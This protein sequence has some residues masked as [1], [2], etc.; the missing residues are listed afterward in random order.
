MR[1]LRLEFQAFG[2]FPG[3]QV[4]DF[5]AL[6]KRGLFVVTGPTGTGKTT[7]FD[8]MVYA[9]YGVLPG[10]RSSDG[11]PRSHHAAAEVETYVTLDFEVDGLCYRVHRTPKWD[12]PK[13]TGTGTTLQ[14]PTALVITLTGDA[15]GSSTEALATQANNTT[16]KCEQLVGLD[17]KQFQRVVLLPQGKFTDFL[18]ATDENREQLLRQL[19]GGE[20]FERATALLKKQ[21]LELD[22]QVKGVDTVMQHHRT[23]AVDALITARAAWLTDIDDPSVDPDGVPIA[24][25]TDEDVRQLIHQL[26][27][28]RDEH[29]QRLGSLQRLATEATALVT[30]A[31][32]DAKRFDD[33]VTTT[34]RLNELEAA[35]ESILADESSSEASRRARPVVVASEKVH[36]AREVALAA[37]DALDVVRASVSAGFAVLQRPQPA[38]DAASV[39][40]AVQVASKQ[41]EDERQL[42][43]AARKAAA[44]ATETEG[45]AVAARVEHDTLIA[46]EANMRSAIASL[47]VLSAD[48][49]PV[50]VSVDKFTAGV[51]AERRA[52]DARTRLDE[53]HAQL[54]KS[55]AEE[56]QVKEAYEVVME[57]FVA[58][59]AP[60]LAE[61]LR[62]GQ[63]CP[64]CGSRDHPDPARDDGR[65]VVDHQAVDMARG[66]WSEESNKV[67][68]Y[69]TTIE[70]LR[71]ELG[72]RAHEPIDAFETALAKAEASLAGAIAAAHELTGVRVEL[73][74][75]NVELAGASQ[76]AQTRGT[77][78]TAF[79]A[80]GA[81]EREEA[82]RLAR[83]VGTIDAE[84]LELNL[85][86]AAALQTG[87]VGIAVLFD[88]VA[89]STAKLA[90]HEARLAEEFGA[91]GY[92]DAHTAAAS[93]LAL[94]VETDLAARA[95]TWHTDLTESTTRMKQLTEQGIPDIRPPLDALR[96]ASEEAYEHAIVAAR[97]FTTAANAHGAAAAEL[98]EAAQVATGSADLRRRR[99]TARTVFKTCNGEAGIR[100]KLERWVLAG[101]LDRVTNAANAHLARMSN[102]RYTLSR[103]T[104]GPSGAGGPSSGSGSTASKGGLT[105]E[106]F[107]AH[108]GRAR[109]TAS[110][111]GGEQFQASLSLALGLADVVSHGGTASGKQ[112][113]ALFVDE[114]F[115]SLDPNALDDAIVALSMLQ[116][117]GRMVGA[118]T[119]VEAMK[120]RLHVGIEV[121]ALEDGRGSTLTVNP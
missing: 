1:P 77:E 42:L 8:A 66:K 44:T 34:L 67:I 3:K 69:Q 30:A 120:E 72:E 68:G 49:E 93:V 19:F 112:F 100:V 24:T 22:D 106:V 105:L 92:A 98:D 70:T 35:R 52:L 57:R 2:S 84:A 115:G 83:V 41:L 45:L 103:S 54:N 118:I 23:N 27:P 10:G 86:T 56:A 28:K 47:L 16:K 4:V 50:A 95:L 36:K 76:A 116:S 117:A 55:T 71:S 40:A 15:S 63:R 113:E 13:K 108:T 94:G 46:A 43:A 29:E 33:A 114:G 85:Q 5:E 74:E 121:T 90:G 18:I 11:D 102:H 48:F 81:A 14:Q 17:A 12:R 39:A 62:D 82:D 96:S 31:E 110:L 109:P 53:T 91:S 21:M 58:T 59:Q 7:V 65:D 88:A 79:A 107:D 6:A 80:R 25:L 89:T 38:F 51:S 87:T 32:S 75:R 20:L 111:S 37:T 104:G 73:A 64:V 60:R 26:E 119:H 101:E 61:L 99:D 97:D 78:V 9:L